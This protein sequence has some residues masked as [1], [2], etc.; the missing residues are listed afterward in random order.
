MSSNN[1]PTST[2]YQVQIGDMTL[3]V[4]TRDRCWDFAVRYSCGCPVSVRILGVVRN[5]VIRV[6][7]NNHSLSCT[8]LRCIVGSETHV[9]SEQCTRCEQFD[10]G[11]PGTYYQPITEL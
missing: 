10:A 4:P 11:L 3:N 2:A 7:K 1:L 5:M 8:V 6:K 9:L